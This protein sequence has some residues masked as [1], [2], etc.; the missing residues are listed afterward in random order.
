MGAVCVGL[1]N[2]YEVAQLDRNQV[3]L[4]RDTIQTFF[5]ITKKEVR[6]GDGVCGS[7]KG[8]YCCVDAHV[9]EIASRWE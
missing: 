7:Y 5:D 2:K 1:Q 4:D 6:A 3:Q 9:S 8:K